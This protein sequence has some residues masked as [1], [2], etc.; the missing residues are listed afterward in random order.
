M[1]IRKATPGD[2]EGIRAVYAA[3][4]AFMDA[5]GNANQWEPGYPDSVI[6]GDIANGNCYAETE[7]GV[8]HGVFVCILGEDPTYRVITD[9]A[10]RNDDPYA[11]IHRLGSDGALPGFTGRC[12]DFC[13]GLC[14]DLRADT[15][16]HNTVMQ[17]LLEKNGFLR[18]GTIITT[19]GTPRIAYH[20]VG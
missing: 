1:E 19:N 9:G 13:K 7:N 16:E 6:P 12:F 10:W 15:H 2:L 11:T 8:I 18:C 5:H 17:H 20:F 4:K 14:P 3:A